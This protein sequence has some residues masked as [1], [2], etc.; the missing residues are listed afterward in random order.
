MNKTKIQT[1]LNE[2][3]EKLDLPLDIALRTKQESIA[4]NLVRSRADV[5]KTDADGSSLLHKAISR[6]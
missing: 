5:S 6:S 4:R 1:K 3:D 2:V